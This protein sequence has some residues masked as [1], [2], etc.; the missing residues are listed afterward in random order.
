MKT[1]PKE[2]PT[3]DIYFHTGNG[4]ITF[5][6]DDSCGPTINMWA[7]S[8]GHQFGRLRLHTTKEGIRLLGEFFIEAA[9]SQ[10]FAEPSGNMISVNS[11]CIASEDESIWY[12]SKGNVV[13][14]APKGKMKRVAKKRSKKSLKKAI[15]S[16][17]E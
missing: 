4:G 12:D 15:R 9:K 1:K 3:K 17:D 13:R 8:H 5:N 2:E 14:Q 7:R 16:D 10:H 11:I 6:V